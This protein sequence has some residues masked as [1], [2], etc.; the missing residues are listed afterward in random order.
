MI[1]RA[2]RISGRWGWLGEILIGAVRARMCGL[3][4]VSLLRVQGRDVEFYEVHQVVVCVNFTCRNDLLMLVLSRM[5]RS[6]SCRSVVG[7]GP[8]RKG[9][10]CGTELG[11]YVRSQEVR[12]G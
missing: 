9:A 4:V 1:E 5:C 2:K 6:C 3:F 8:K 7:E 10:P 12:V 11:C